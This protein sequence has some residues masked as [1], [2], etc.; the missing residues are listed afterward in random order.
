MEEEDTACSGKH[1]NTPYFYRYNKGRGNQFG[2]FLSAVDMDYSR[3]TKVNVPSNNAF[4]QKTNCVARR[5]ANLGP[6]TM[7]TG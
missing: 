3:T 2:L 4:F 6:N 7:V 5:K 1:S